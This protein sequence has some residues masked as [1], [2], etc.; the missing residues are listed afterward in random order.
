MSTEEAVQQE[1][2]EAATSP[3]PVS[4]TPTETT[5]P[6]A[7]SPPEP[8]ASRPSGSEQSD[9]IPSWRLREEAEARRQAEDRARTLEQRYN[10][11][12]AHWR[13]N[14]PQPKQPD[15]YADP[16]AGRVPPCHSAAGPRPG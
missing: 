4:E 13:Q 16:A 15:F 2:F 3:E 8:A 5:T 7:P 1:L 10:E 11:A 6:E 9:S 14:Q 12:M